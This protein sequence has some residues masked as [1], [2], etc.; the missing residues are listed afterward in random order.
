MGERTSYE[1]G[2]S[3]SLLIADAT[4]TPY[5]LYPAHSSLHICLFSVPQH[6]R[7]TRTWIQW[8]GL[9]VVLVVTWRC[10]RDLWPRPLALV[11]TR[12]ARM[13][14]SVSV[15]PTTRPSTPDRTRVILTMSP[16][17][18]SPAKQPTI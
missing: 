13:L 3:Q 15:L 4:C 10:I 7:Y 1:Q 9:D 6:Y 8:N 12:N 2:R 11:L 18:S 14:S 17:L 5:T 16:L